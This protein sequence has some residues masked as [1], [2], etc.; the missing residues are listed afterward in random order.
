MANTEDE[1]LEVLNYDPH[2]PSPPFV[3][4]ERLCVVDPGND[5]TCRAASH[6]PISPVLKEFP[7]TTFHIIYAYFAAAVVEFS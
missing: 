3:V 1:A 4:V 6:G 5:G 2:T 7:T